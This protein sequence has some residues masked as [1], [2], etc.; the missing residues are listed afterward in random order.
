[1]SVLDKRIPS[2][3]GS[4]RIKNSLSKRWPRAL[5]IYK[6]SIRKSTKA[7]SDSSSKSKFTSRRRRVLT[8][9]PAALISILN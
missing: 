3:C 6:I 4:K 8:W 9:R 5:Y 7:F 2:F 1:M